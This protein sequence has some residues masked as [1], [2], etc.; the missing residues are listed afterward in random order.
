[1]QATLGHYVGVS[2]R[3]PGASTITNSCHRSGDA[4]QSGGAVFTMGPNFGKSSF[5][6]PVTCVSFT[7]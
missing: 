4:N 1:M 2:L 7:F 3:T 5:D 6:Q